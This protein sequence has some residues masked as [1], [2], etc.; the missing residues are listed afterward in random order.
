MNETNE[1]RKKRLEKL[2]ATVESFELTKA[3]YFDKLSD[4]TIKQMIPFF[5]QINEI[6][7]SLSKFTTE[8]NNMWDANRFKTFVRFLKLVFQNKF[9][10]QKITHKDINKCANGL[11]IG[12][13]RDLKM[14]SD[15]L[16]N[17]LQFKT[18]DK[19]FTKLIVNLSKILK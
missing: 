8:F 10:A 13:Y 2:D 4:E 11:Y 6:R 3:M 12:T 19:H 18:N 17:F 16:A 15:E 7:Q 5:D 1:Y 9:R 14:Y